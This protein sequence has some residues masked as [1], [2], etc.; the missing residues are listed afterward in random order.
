MWNCKQRQREIWGF[1]GTFFDSEVVIISYFINSI[2]KRSH[3][4]LWPCK[5][6]YDPSGTLLIDQ[7]PYYP[8]SFLPITKFCF[9]RSLV[10]IFVFKAS[11]NKIKGTIADIFFCESSFIRDNVDNYFYLFWFISSYYSP[12]ASNKKIPKS[13]HILFQEP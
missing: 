9:V 11:R 7:N 10:N 3:K 2:H 1:K 12:I 6:P 5:N 8:P 4:P 13:R